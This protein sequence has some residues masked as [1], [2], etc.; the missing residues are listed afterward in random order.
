MLAAAIAVAGCGLSNP[1]QSGRH[2]T[3]ATTTSAPA[4]TAPADAPDPAPERGG[5]IPKRAQAAQ[6]QL[7]D[8]AAE[9]T[10]QAALERYAR[11]YLNWTSARVI[12]TQHQLA[13]ISLGQARALAQQAAATASRDTQLKA[14]QLANSGQVISLA[15]GQDA[16]RGQWVI[17]TSELTTGAGDYAG[18]PPTLHIIYAR[19][20]DTPQGWVVKRMATP[21]L[22][23]A[24]PRTSTSTRIRAPRPQYV[25]LASSR[26]SPPPRSAL[27]VELV[28]P[29]LF[30]SSAPHP[31]LIPS[32]G[33]TVSIFAT[34]L[35]VAVLP[36]ILIALRFQFGRVT[37]LLGDVLARCGARRQRDPRRARARPL[38][39]PAAALPAAPSARVPRDRRGRRRVARR[40][41]A[42]RR[43]PQRAAARRC[44]LRARRL[45][46][47]SPLPRASRCC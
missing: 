26:C 22:A 28:D 44:R 21:E 43:R 41:T 14:S 2:P 30:A 40:P 10:P 37:R 7:A 13:A 33:A 11:V 46:C 9:P 18:L 42:P 47:C 5:T 35:R 15:P 38:A 29:G 31:T 19:V 39:R 16:A 4:S 23:A 24:V 34:N 36:F 8:G 20:T 32:V 17:V 1:Y 6:N 45:S 27:V 3:T 12:A 25:A